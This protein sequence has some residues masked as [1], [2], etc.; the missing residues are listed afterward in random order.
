M[1]ILQVKRYIIACVVY[2]KKTAADLKPANL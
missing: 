1:H 2:N